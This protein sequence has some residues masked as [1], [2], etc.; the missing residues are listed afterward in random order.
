LADSSPSRQKLD[1][2]LEK[3]WLNF[4]LLSYP[5]PLTQM[6]A[7]ER[8]N[9]HL[10][11]SVFGT[12]RPC[13]TAAKQ[14]QKAANSYSLHVKKLRS[15]LAS[16]TLFFDHESESIARHWRSKSEEICLSVLFL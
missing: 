5:T 2:W 1:I 7:F 4:D 12:V 8:K 11:L 6:A 16:E 3:S 10:V 14:K 15:I 13:G 9:L